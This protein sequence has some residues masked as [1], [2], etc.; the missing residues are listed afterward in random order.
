[1]GYRV[2]IHSLITA[3]V[4]GDFGPLPAI[5]KTL[6]GVV[7]QPETY[8]RDF[9]KECKSVIKVINMYMLPDYMGNYPEDSLPYLWRLTDY[10]G[11]DG[12]LQT[13]M[14]GRQDNA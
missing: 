5:R 13:V 9:I 1:M 7:S 6:S 2:P 10:C 11:I 8:S 12:L 3:L 4:G 14:E